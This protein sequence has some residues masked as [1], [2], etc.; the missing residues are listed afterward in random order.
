LTTL[1]LGWW[2]V[3]SF[4]ITPFLI[5][6]NLIRYLLCLGMEPVPPG[7]ER[8]RL[9]EDAVKR[10]NPHAQSLFERLNAGEK[11]PDVARE[12]AE[13]AIVTPGQVMLYAQA[14]SQAQSAK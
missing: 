8:P 12:I 7:A 2:G 9:T 3:I 14:V 5:L 11:L 13:R 10:L 6:N 4:I 1:V